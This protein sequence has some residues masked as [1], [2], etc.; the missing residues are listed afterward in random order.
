M[1]KIEICNFLKKFVKTKVDEKICQIDKHHSK[2][3]ISQVKFYYLFQ[4][5][6]FYQMS[7]DFYDFVIV[8][9]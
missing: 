1:F 3:F 9:G 2:I 6:D 7:D 8:H 4:D 5:E